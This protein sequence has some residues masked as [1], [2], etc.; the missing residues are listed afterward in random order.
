MKFFPSI[1]WKYSMV[2]LK[3]ALSALKEKKNNF[4]CKLGYAGA[5][6]RRESGV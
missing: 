6:K 3:L 2:K 5:V 4:S 1:S